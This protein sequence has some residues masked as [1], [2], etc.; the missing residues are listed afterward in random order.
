[1]RHLSQCLRPHP[2]GQFRAVSLPA[3][4]AYLTLHR[5]N[6]DYLWMTVCMKRNGSFFRKPK[7]MTLRY[8]SPEE[9]VLFAGQRACVNIWDMGTPPMQVGM[10]FINAWHV[11]Q[12]HPHWLYTEGWAMMEHSI[13]THHAWLTGP[14]GE[15]E[16]PTWRSL[17]ADNPERPGR[18][19]YLGVT[20]SDIEMLNWAEAK[21]YP[22][23]LAYNE[24]T[25]PDVL[26]L[27]P[28]EAIAKAAASL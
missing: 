19:S 5:A 26:A 9:I 17:L 6:I 18:C 23:V 7:G 11:S 14:N 16:D 2:D 24:M 25:D 10:C 8:H 15:V 22:N 20:F 27:G 3:D 28:H 21:G 4:E 1:M 12:R 13:P